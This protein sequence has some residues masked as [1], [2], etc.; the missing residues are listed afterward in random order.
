MQVH[1]LTLR[2]DPTRGVLDDATLSGFVRDKVILAVRDHFFQ[3]GSTPHLALV[4]EYRLPAPT[5][6]GKPDGRSQTRTDELR[7]SLP[8]A[9]REVFDLLRSWRARLAQ[10]EGLPA[11]AVLTNAQLEAVA[12][13]RPASRSALL[14]VSGLGRKKAERYGK[15][16]LAIVGRA[17]AEAAPTEESEAG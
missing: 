7:D 9:E 2:Y 3:V 5:S 12:R 15:D 8:P 4:I 11:Y 14:E 1:V 17:S 10:D 6:S 16:L 13:R